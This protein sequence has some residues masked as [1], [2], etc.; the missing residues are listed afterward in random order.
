MSGRASI[1]SAA[2]IVGAGLSAG[3][4]ASPPESPLPAATN[5]A[6]T[7]APTAIVLPADFPVGSWVVTITEQDMRDGGI[8]DAAL[9]RENIGKF[10]KT[11]GSDGTFTLTQDAPN[12]V[13]WPVYRGTFTPTGADGIEERTTFPPEF[14]GEVL[15]Y[16]WKREGRVVRFII[17]DAQDPMLPIV[18]NTYPWQPN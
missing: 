10:T 3:C 6:V 16:T 7:P 9:I 12:P 14:V 13:E 2:L 18:T 5:G 11:Y 8:T 4:G 15:H 1:L 17:L